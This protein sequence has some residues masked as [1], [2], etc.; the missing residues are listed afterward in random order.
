MEP[1]A[2]NKLHIKVTTLSNVFTIYLSG[3]FSFEAHREFKTAY[4]NQLDN[5]K[6]GNIVVN[7]S[8][9]E[10]LDSSALGMLLVMRDYVQAANKTLTLSKPSPIALRTF[11]IA[12]FNKIFTIN[13]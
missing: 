10:Y 7:L 13:L 12:S 11:D 5:S 2:V 1:V 8:E 4:K 9:V 3:N 6:I